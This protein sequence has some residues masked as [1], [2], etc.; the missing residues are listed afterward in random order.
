MLKGIVTKLFNLNQNL[1]PVIKM[2]LFFQ[3]IS[4]KTLVKLFNKNN[5]IT[6]ENYYMDILNIQKKNFRFEL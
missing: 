4:I 3:Q 5:F 2:E 6:L 1:K